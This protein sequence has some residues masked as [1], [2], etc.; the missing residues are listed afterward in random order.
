MELGEMNDG[1][2][3][4]NHKMRSLNTIK[5]SLII[6]YLK[7]ILN[8]QMEM[9]GNYSNGMSMNKEFSALTKTE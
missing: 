7:G 4:K 2:E 3:F 6:P 1:F 5:E 8:L 9:C